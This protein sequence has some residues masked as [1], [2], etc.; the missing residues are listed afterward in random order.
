MAV[1]CAF[2]LVQSS[3]SFPC[4]PEIR[5]F[6]GLLQNKLG[7][8]KLQHMCSELAWLTKIPEGD[9]FCFVLIP[10]IVSGC[11]SAIAR[12]ISLH[13]I[14]CICDAALCVSKM[15]YKTYIYQN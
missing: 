7:K 6:P 1:Q 2:A 4:L 9:F 10:L 11:S 13:P 8:I 3:L 5:T 12:K 15:I 14:L